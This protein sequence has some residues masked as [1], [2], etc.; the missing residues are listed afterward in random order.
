MS[1]SSSCLSLPWK[2]HRKRAEQLRLGINQ[3]MVEYKN[4]PLGSVAVSIGVTGYPDHGRTSEEIMQIVDD[5]LF[6]GK[7][8]GRNRVF[9]AEVGKV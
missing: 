1:S 3:I 4:Q 7:K 6:K 8:G 9:V 5:A 2:N